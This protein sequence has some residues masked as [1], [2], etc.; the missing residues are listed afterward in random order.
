[1][2]K[3]YGSKVCSDCVACKARLDA[4]GAE[5]DFVDITESMKNLK[6]FLRLR[7]SEIV[8][9]DARQNGYVGIPALIP[10]NGVITLN[11]KQ[12][13]ADNGIDAGS[14]TVSGAACRLDGTGC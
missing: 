11:W 4:G 3:I 9:E 14:E 10:D 2:L 5:Y 7:D 8:F 12:Y 1:M 13:L 6:E